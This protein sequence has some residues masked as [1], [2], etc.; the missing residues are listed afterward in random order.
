MLV[1]VE[2]NKIWKGPFTGEMTIAEEVYEYNYPYYL[3]ESLLLLSTYNDYYRN[4]MVKRK[5]LFIESYSSSAVEKRMPIKAFLSQFHKSNQKIATI[6]KEILIILKDWQ[7]KGLIDS[8]FKL[9]SNTGNEKKLTELSP[10]SLIK[11]DIICFYE[12]IQSSQIKWK[13]TCKKSPSFF[14][15]R[16]L[17]AR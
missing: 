16:T 13:I 2:F 17:F 1:D 8:R 3:P 6:K 15:R 9:I 14:F 12:K 7:K 5:L 10:S 11:C 4:Y